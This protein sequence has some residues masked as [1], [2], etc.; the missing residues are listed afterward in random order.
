M[1]RK[2]WGAMTTKSLEGAKEEWQNIAIL[3]TL[4][5]HAMA[6]RANRSMANREHSLLEISIAQKLVYK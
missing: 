1:E 3:G 6:L 4:S 2:E 5:M